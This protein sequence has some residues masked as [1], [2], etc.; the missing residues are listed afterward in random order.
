MG[1]GVAV[2]EE[3]ATETAPAVTVTCAHAVTLQLPSALTKYVVVVPGE[4]LIEE[5]VPTGVPGQP[6]VYQCHDAP[7]P[8]EPPPTVN[9]VEPPPHKGLGLA[10]ADEGAVEGLLTLTVTWAQPVVLQFPCAL[11]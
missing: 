7:V 10:E 9:V 6:P 8:S 11:T 1:F 2:I 3:G 5:P 4:T